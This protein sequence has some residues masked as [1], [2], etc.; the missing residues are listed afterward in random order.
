[1]ST[2]AFGDTYLLTHVRAEMTPCHWKIRICQEI[3]LNFETC[4]IKYKKKKKRDT[5]KEFFLLQN[6][7]LPLNKHEKSAACFK[8]AAFCLWLFHWQK[9]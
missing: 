4:G 1:M 8:E 3:Q 5:L 2:F 7:L 9:G 6:I